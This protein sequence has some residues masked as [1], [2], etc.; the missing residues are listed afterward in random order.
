M[1]STAW[2]LFTWVRVVG[3][4]GCYAIMS[5]GLGLVLGLVLVVV[6]GLVLGLGFR[7]GFRDCLSSVANTG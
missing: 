1:A 7:V 5:L 2:K 3:L 6:L 4:L